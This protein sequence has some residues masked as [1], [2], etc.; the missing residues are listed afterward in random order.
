MGATRISDDR[1]RCAIPLNGGF[2]TTTTS[3][4]SN[5][6]ERIETRISTADASG[7]LGVHLGVR[8][9]QLMLRERAYWPG[10]RTAVERYCKECTTCRSAQRGPTRRQGLMQTYPSAGPLFNAIRDAEPDSSEQRELFTE[11]TVMMNQVLQR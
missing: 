11:R 5:Y 4:T 9:M 2:R 6:A 8:K 7:R 10:W 1:S 3:V